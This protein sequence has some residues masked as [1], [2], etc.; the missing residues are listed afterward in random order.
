MYLSVFCHQPESVAHTSDVNINVIPQVAD[1]LQGVTVII[2][3]SNIVVSYRKIYSKKIHF[4]IFDM[5]KHSHYGYV[6]IKVVRMHV[7]ENYY[8]YVF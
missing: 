7:T 2:Q 3:T 4:F 1:N 6:E 8:L 5:Q